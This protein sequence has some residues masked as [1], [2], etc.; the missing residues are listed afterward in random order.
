MKNVLQVQDPESD[1]DVLSMIRQKGNFVS[2]VELHSQRL[3]CMTVIPCKLSK[4][5]KLPA[6]PFAGF[7]SCCCRTP[8][9]LAQ[10]PLNFLQ[11]LTTSPDGYVTNYI[12]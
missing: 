3:V 12:V 6:V 4:C 1:T 2:H 11:S 7:A 10:W 8:L 9:A 5:I